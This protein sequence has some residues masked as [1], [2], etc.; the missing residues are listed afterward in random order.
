[1]CQKWFAK[2]HAEDFSLNNALHFG[3]LIE[4]DYNQVIS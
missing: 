2:L 4:V 1:M 3:K